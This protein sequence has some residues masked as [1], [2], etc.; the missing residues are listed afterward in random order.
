MTSESAPYVKHFESLRDNLMIATD[1]L[2]SGLDDVDT[3][4]SRAIS[5]F[6][7]TSSGISTDYSNMFIMLVDELSSVSN[8]VETINTL[9]NHM[10]VSADILS[11][12]TSSTK[13]E[14]LALA[15]H[16]CK[17]VKLSEHRYSFVR[18]ILV[19]HLQII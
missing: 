7:C 10:D 13:A 11:N 16:A 9:I 5:E 14:A 17:S 19:D 18:A 15:K 1:L 4:Y 3:E 6:A 12:N 8:P 2:C